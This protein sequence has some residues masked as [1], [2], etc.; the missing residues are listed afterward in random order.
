M[1]AES[2]RSHSIFAIMVDS[3]DT[4]TKRTTTGAVVLE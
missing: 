2:S 1:N 4:A 3:Y